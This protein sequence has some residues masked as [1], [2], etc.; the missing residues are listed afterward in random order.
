MAPRKQSEQQRRKGQDEMLRMLGTTCRVGVCAAALAL[1][2]CD[3]L[4]TIAVLPHSL[5]ITPVDTLITE[6]DQAQ[7]RVTVLD[8]DGNVIP[9]PPD[10]ARPTWVVAP[11][12][13]IEIERDGTVT[14]L[15]GA[16][17]RLVAGVAGLTGEVYVRTNPLD[18][19]FSAGAVY[20]TQAAQNLRGDV[21]L[22]AGRPAFLRIFPV[23]D[24]IGFFEPRARATFYR[25]GEVI[26]GEVV[27]RA[28][29]NSVGG[30]IFTEPREAILHNSN[31]ALIPGSVIQPGVEMVVELDP[32]G[33]VPLAPGSQLRFPAEGRMSLNVVEMPVYHQTIVPTVQ[34]LYS[35]SES[36]VGWAEG[37][38]EDDPFFRFTRKV[39]PIGEMKVTIH[40]PVHTSVDL[41]DEVGWNRWIREVLTI[42]ELE[43]RQGYYYGAT[44]LPPRSAYGG[45]GY[46]QTPVSVGVNRTQTYTHEIGHNMSL[47][48]IDCGGPSGADPA[49][50]HDP[51]SIGIYGFDVEASAIVHP[52]Q[53]VD[54]MTYCDPTW[55]SDYSFRIALNRRLQL[56]SE[57][58]RAAWEAIP[59]ES[60]I[61]LW[62]GRTGE[63]EMLMEPAFLVEARSSVPATGGPY[64]LEGYG[65]GGELRFGF[66]FTPQPVEFGGEHFHFNVPYD[67]DRDGGLERVVLSGPEG[68]VLLGPSSTSPMAIIINR[69]SGQVRAILREWNG[70]MALAVGDTEILVSDGLPRAAR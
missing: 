5:V 49:Y 19:E 44:P 68:E 65:P 13:A 63:G 38:T 9:G 45:L 60:T 31:N 61:M 64:R 52:R 62:G 66:D 59:Q 27:H 30:K 23:G 26:G 16:A 20:L 58:T 29:M 33:I 28:S 54:L 25:D 14:A 43:G 40:E 67:P 48:H 46:L 47:R 8:E 17:V 18:L 50:P 21:P 41:T 12:R 39:M 6:G 53:Y 7:L 32:D 15:G 10:W 1:A 35:A 24:E 56:E 70:S 69:S 11:R 22:I 3:D 42:W 37:K 57:P 55:I 4:S 2:G 51:N 34:T 36:V